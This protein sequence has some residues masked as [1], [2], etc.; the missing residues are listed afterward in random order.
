MGKTPRL[1]SS[2]VLVLA[3]LASL[4]SIDAVTAAASPQAHS[5]STKARVVQ[6][7][8]AVVSSVSPLTHRIRVVAKA[9]GATY[10]ID[11]SRTTFFYGVRP[12]SIV[13]GTKITI[14]GI[15]KGR[16]ILAQRISTRRWSATTVSGISA[17]DFSASGPYFGI[18][19]VGNV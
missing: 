6:L 1:V 13:K 8:G 5:T 4:A 9:T 2:A 17:P 15:L 19:Y 3:S 16:T 18:H 14:A 11:Y 12:K 10:T 7:N